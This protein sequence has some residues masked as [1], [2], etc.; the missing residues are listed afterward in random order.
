MNQKP[1]CRPDLLGEGVCGGTCPEI[2]KW[3]NMG[4]FSASVY[5]YL[6]FKS[7]TA[8]TDGHLN[9]WHPTYGISKAKT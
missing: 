1:H 9:C 2:Y 6:G 8:E 3:H 7:I 5:Q 4:L